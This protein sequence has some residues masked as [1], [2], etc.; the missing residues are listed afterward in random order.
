MVVAF[1]SIFVGLNV[2]GAITVRYLDNSKF[3]I[4]RYVSSS[5][6]ILAVSSL[7]ILIFISIAG[8]NLAELTAIPLKWLYIA[9]LV[10]CFQ[11]VVQLL[12]ALWQASKKPIRYGAK[13][14]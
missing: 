5:L 8:D 6:A 1:I 12:M 13:V 10:A 2:H 9:V 3:D 14:A 7:I 4:P 11:F